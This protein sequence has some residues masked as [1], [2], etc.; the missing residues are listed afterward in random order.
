MA[1]WRGGCIDGGGERWGD[2][3][4]AL[5]GEADGEVPRQLRWLELR[6]VPDLFTEVWERRE[7]KVRRKREKEERLC[8]RG[9]AWEK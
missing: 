2:M 3:V 4:D 7:R 9:E 5:M 1:R 8:G 6:S